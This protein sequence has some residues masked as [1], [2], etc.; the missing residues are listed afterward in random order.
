MLFILLEHIAISTLFFFF[1]SLFD[2]HL[3]WMVITLITTERCFSCVWMNVSVVSALAYL[4]VCVVYTCSLAHT[5]RI[6]K[7]EYFTFGRCKQRNRNQLRCQIIE[8]G[9]TVFPHIN[10][11]RLEC[12]SVC[13]C[14][15]LHWVLSFYKPTS[16]THTSYSKTTIS[17]NVNHNE[18]L[19]T[20]TQSNHGGGAI[21]LKHL[22]ALSSHIHTHT[23]IKIKQNKY[24][25]FTFIWI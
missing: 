8:Y 4:W 5:T 25:H 23:K 21:Y 11:Y 18:N 6:S 1:H 12:M 14:V 17:F 2:F 3:V 24:D 9:K 22:R 20:H 19:T 16:N 15:C 7:I 10:F 13:V